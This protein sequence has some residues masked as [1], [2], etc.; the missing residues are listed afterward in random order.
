[1]GD[2]H[3]TAAKEAM[4]EIYTGD[5]GQQ[6]ARGEL[7]HEKWL[8]GKLRKA[9]EDGAKAER[10]A[11]AELVANKAGRI[12]RVSPEFLPPRE[13]SYDVSTCR[14]LENDIRARRTGGA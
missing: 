1:M 8:S 9:A 14:L 6:I 5:A 10:E 12:V 4:L 13:A 11:C 2:K 7:T 3:D